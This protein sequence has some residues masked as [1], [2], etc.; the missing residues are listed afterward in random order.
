MAKFGCPERFITMI[1]QFHDAM[2]ARVQDDYE[3]SETFPVTNGVKQGCVPAPTLF[4]IMF[5]AM[6][7]DA[8]HDSEEGIPI[9]YR[10]DGKLFNQSRLQ[11]VTKVKETTVLSMPPVNRLCKQL[12]TGY[13]GHATIWPLH[14]HQEHRG[15]VPTPPWQVPPEIQHQSKWYS[16]QSC[17]QVHIP[18]QHPVTP[19]QH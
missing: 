18:G 9:R 14:Q 2:M 15:H 16:A 12:L 4:S 17:G 5:S 1:R 3:T 19:D 7:T 13:L 6:L 8:F 11:A 10:T